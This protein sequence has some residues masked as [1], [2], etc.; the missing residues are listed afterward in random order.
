MCVC[1]CVCLC[2]CMCVCVNASV[3]VCVCVC[4]GV[5]V[6]VCECMCALGEEGGSG[7]CRKEFNRRIISI[8]AYSAIK[9]KR[10]IR[11]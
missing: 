1:E 11:N 6:Y 5:L 10:F 2:V 9:C 8:I 4:V 7:E 3:C